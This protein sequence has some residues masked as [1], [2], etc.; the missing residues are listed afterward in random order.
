M[1][2]DMEGSTRVHRDWVSLT[3]LATWLISSRFGLSA[4]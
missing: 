4:D 2:W 1:S 3:L